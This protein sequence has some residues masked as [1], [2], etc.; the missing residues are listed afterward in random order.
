MV[1]NGDPSLTVL[2][3]L[4]RKKGEKDL[5]RREREDEEE[6]RIEDSSEKMGKNVPRRNRGSERDRVIERGNVQ[7]ETKERRW[8]RGFK[9]TVTLK[10][11]PG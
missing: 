2:G 10:S 6:E 3:E 7:R 4:S 1:Q 11:K 5:R 8:K 9:Q